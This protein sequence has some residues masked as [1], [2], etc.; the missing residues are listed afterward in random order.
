MAAYLIGTSILGAIT[1]SVL[2]SKVLKPAVP[3]LY[4][5]SDVIPALPRAFGLT[6]FVLTG[7]SFFLIVWGA[8]VGKA[9]QE[10][11]TKAEKDGEK[12]LD[13]YLLPNLYVTGESANAKAFNSVQRSHQHVFETLTQVYFGAIVGSLCFPLTT[14]LSTLLWAYARV[15]WA[16]SYA[17]EGASGR[18]SNPMSTFIWRGFFVNIALSIIVAGNFVFGTMY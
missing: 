14:A 7:F 6:L 8:Q 16:Q 13:R 9:R 12:D 15:V 3:F 17:K 11:R 4:E 10:Y 5:K 2:E 18:Y 1:A